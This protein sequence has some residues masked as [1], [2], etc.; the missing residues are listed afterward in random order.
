MFF[1]MAGGGRRTLEA[2]ILGAEFLFPIPLQQWHWIFK[3]EAVMSAMSHAVRA[4]Q[5]LA[6]PKGT[7]N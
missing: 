3:V 5:G 2:M 7:G 4:Q 6:V 1:W